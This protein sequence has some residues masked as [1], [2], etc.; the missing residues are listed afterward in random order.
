M[1]HNP[2]YSYCIP[3]DRFHSKKKEVKKKNERYDCSNLFTEPCMGIAINTS[4]AC[5]WGNL[6]VHGT[7]GK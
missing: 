5:I 6:Y 2:A 7:S 4:A 3:A 1:L